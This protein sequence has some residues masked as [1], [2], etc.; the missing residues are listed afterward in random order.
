MS[1]LEDYQIEKIKELFNVE[2]VEQTL[3]Q[4][5]E[6]KLTPQQRAVLRFI[7]NNP[8]EQYIELQKTFTM[9]DPLVI[10]LVIDYGTPSDEYEELK[11]LHDELLSKE[12]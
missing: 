12:I 9:P 7:V 10:S 3:T 8:E 2:V 6:D 1:V 4:I 11:Q 5:R